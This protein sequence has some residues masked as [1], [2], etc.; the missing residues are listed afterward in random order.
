MIGN[1]QIADLRA[2]ATAGA[3]LDVNGNSYSADDLKSL[4]A[5]LVKG[6]TL[7]IRNSGQ[8]STAE[9]QAI[10]RARPGQVVLG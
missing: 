5:A 9:C 6:A 4:A 1:R 10:A 7:R 2:I 3:S 8:L